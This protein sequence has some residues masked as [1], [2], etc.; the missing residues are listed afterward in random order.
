MDPGS[1]EYSGYSNSPIPRRSELKRFNSSK[2]MSAEIEQVVT[3]LLRTT[4][5]LLEA[6]NLWSQLRTS[7]V[8]IFEIHCTLESQFYLVSQS[9]E[10]AHINTNDLAWIPH[11]LRQSIADCMEQQPST[12][13][14][15]KYLPGIR[16]VIVHL[17]H[18][19]KGKQQLL[20]EQQEMTMPQ[21]MMPNNNNYIS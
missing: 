4:K 21:P 10:E 3:R 1:R 9:F 6:L 20:R 17:L 11:K 15:D 14:L 7:T 16:D 19:L 2:S 12:A 5:S 13:A 18:G 8:D